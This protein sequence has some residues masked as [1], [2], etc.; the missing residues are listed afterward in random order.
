M[1]RTTATPPGANPFNACIRLQLQEDR[2]RVAAWV[3]EYRA[4]H[5]EPRFIGCVV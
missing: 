3:R 2:A 4:R 1:D 5:A